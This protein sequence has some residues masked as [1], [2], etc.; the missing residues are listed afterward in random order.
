M[1]ELFSIENDE[2]NYF[3]VIYCV[4]NILDGKKYIGQTIQSVKTRWACHIS[5]S[6][7]RQKC[8]KFH[9]AI[10]KYGKDNFKIKIIDHADNYEELNDKETYWIKTLDTRDN[11]YNS[12]FDGDGKGITE[13]VKLKISLANK[14]REISEEHRK[15]LILGAKRNPYTFKK[16]IDH[17]NNKIV[18]RLNKKNYTISKVFES[19]RLAEVNVSG[20]CSG[21]IRDSIKHK[22]IFN[23]FYWIYQED[24]E[25]LDSLDDYFDKQK[26]ERIERKKIKEKEKLKEKKTRIENKKILQLNIDDFSIVNEY[27]LIKDILEK[28]NF[29]MTNNSI[30]KAILNKTEYRGYY[31]IRKYDFKKI[32]N[33]QTYFCENNFPNYK[34]GTLH[35]LGAVNQLDENKIL[36]KEWVSCATAEKFFNGKKGNNIYRAIQKNKKAFGFYWKLTSSK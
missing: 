21:V 3:G 29:K 11:G 17:P 28:L 15:K 31:W 33:I 7:N 6:K 9:R 35:Y 5:E 34:I 10:A 24:Y 27:Y 26:E 12:N 36:I 23:D 8:V 4:E 2:N 22:R 16:G 13:E 19:A 20:N 1:D 32:K 25:K 14:G 30:T 18:Y